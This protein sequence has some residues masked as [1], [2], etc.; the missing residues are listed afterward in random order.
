MDKQ[1]IRVTV[2]GCCPPHLSLA[3]L[4]YLDAFISLDVDQT[5]Q[6][7]YHLSTQCWQPKDPK[8]A[9]QPGL[10]I[11]LA[12]PGQVASAISVHNCN[13]LTQ[14]DP[15]QLGHQYQSIV[16]KISKT[17][18]Y[19]HHVLSHHHFG[20]PR[21]LLENLLP[22]R[23]FT[24]PWPQGMLRRRRSQESALLPAKSGLRGCSFPVAISSTKLYNT[25]FRV[26]SIHIIYIY[27]VIFQC[28]A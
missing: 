13:R 28:K 14:A 18:S 8:V 1:I 5:S 22:S 16:L 7:S 9:R 25:H 6:Q 12:K 21:E 2:S 4:L 27:I 11:L 3:S 20:Q 17:S 24:L 10:L 19:Y 15:H 26:I 23:T